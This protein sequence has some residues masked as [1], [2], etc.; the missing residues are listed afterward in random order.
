MDRTHVAALIVQTQAAADAKSPDD[1]SNPLAPIAGKSVTGWIVDAALNASVRR[2]GVIAP[3]PNA[4]VRSEL[5]TRSDEALIEFVSPTVDIVETLTFAIE[6][7]GSELTLRDS[8]HVLLLPAESPQI[9]STELRSLIDT[10]VA[11]GAAATLLAPAVDTDL[12]TGPVIIRDETGQVT[13]ISETFAEPTSIMCIRAAL[14]IP[15]LHRTVVPTWK[16]GAPLAEIAGVLTE[17]GHQ[18]DVIERPE[19]IEVI[20][21]AATRTRIEMEL[22]DRIV[23]RWIERGVVMPDP[24][25]VSIDET[26]VLGKGVTVL[27]GSVLE[28]A[29]VVGDGAIIGPNTQLHNALVGSQA[30][31]PHSV[32]R[33]SEVATRQQVQPF[34]VLGAAS[35]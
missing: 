21:S 23:N 32:V 16:S 33:N 4:D 20:R 15:A 25:Q 30:E 10:H 24:R 1:A 29:T 3:A 11:S 6:R 14:L 35:R 8:T 17:A 7:L 31:V 12:S 18:V 2:V 26:V 9:E 19:P 28:A 27:P 34:S 13:S 22:R 5:A